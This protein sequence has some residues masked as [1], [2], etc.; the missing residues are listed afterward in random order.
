MVTDAELTTLDVWCSS[1]LYGWHLSLLN[2]WYLSFV[3][4]N[5]AALNTMPMLPKLPDIYTCAC[6]VVHG[7][8]ASFAGKHRAQSNDYLNKVTYKTAGM[9]LTV[10]IT[11]LKQ[12]RR[13]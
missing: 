8:N 6:M 12:K 4:A 3:L 11:R 1:A 5:C 2:G 10:S 13:L 9:I 7:S